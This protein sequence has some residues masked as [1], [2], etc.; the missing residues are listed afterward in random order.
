LWASS[1]SRHLSP[2]VHPFLDNDRFIIRLAHQQGNILL[3]VTQTQAR[4]LV[5]AAAQSDQ[6]VLHRPSLLDRSSCRFQAGNALMTVM[7]QAGDPDCLLCLVPYDRTHWLAWLAGERPLFQGDLFH[8][9]PDSIAHRILSSA[10]RLSVRLPLGR[11][12]SRS[13]RS[14]AER[15]AAGQEQEAVCRVYEENFG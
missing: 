3:P 13:R 10:A 2:G 5:T 15:P 12:K 6:I 14:L 4:T 9:L 1:F 8:I 7:N 11:L